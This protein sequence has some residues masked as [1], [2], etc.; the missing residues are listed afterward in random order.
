MLKKMI[1]ILAILLHTY[2]MAQN[3]YKQQDSCL[4][5]NPI[6]TEVLS[7]IF[8]NPPPIAN[9]YTKPFFVLRFFNL[10]SD[11]YFTIGYC[12][13]FP[14]LI[15][16]QGATVE[17]DTNCLYYY[18]INEHRLLIN[19]YC[20]S[21]GHGLYFPCKKTNQQALIEKS[22]SPPPIFLHGENVISYGITYQVLQDSIVKVPLI[23][24][25]KY[26]KDKEIKDI[27]IRRRNCRYND[28][29]EFSVDPTD[30]K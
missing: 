12:Y 27:V 26:K 11:L 30:D 13:T 10:K 3:T 19:D 6:L 8:R 9:D 14:T 17:L 4:Y 23:I 2:A 1:L 15:L 7:K 22:T 25:K 28:S 18:L 24:P 5:M 21:T 29:F 20:F 16:V